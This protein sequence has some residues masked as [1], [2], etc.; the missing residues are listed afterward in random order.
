M[1]SLPRSFL[2]YKAYL[3]GH[4]DAKYMPELLHHTFV[5]MKDLAKKDISLV[6][7]TKTQWKQ[8]SEGVDVYIAIL[9]GKS[10]SKIGD[11]A[12]VKKVTKGPLFMDFT[13]NYTT[14][15]TYFTG[16]LDNEVAVKKNMAGLVASIVCGKVLYGGVWA[17]KLRAFNPTTSKNKAKICSFVTNLMWRL[18]CIYECYTMGV[19]KL[20]KDIFNLDVVDLVLQRQ[21]HKY[22]GLDVAYEFRKDLVQVKAATVILEYTK[23]KGLNKDTIIEKTNLPDAVKNYMRQ[24]KAY[25]QQG[26]WMAIKSKL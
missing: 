23:V 21:S 7:I 17:V 24:L 10:I 22:P 25:Q 6:K 15:S 16:K 13:Y 3:D 19:N 2:E 5:L 18:A 4:K 14:D 12:P 26:T 11:Y 20:G 8:I 9:S 1:M